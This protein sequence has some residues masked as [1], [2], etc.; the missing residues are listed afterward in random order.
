MQLA[1]VTR[2]CVIDV[3]K[4]LTSVT[5]NTQHLLLVL[6]GSVEIMFGTLSPCATRVAF[7]T[8]RGT[9][10]SIVVF[11]WLP[12]PLLLDVS[13]AGSPFSLPL[14]WSDWFPDLVSPSGCLP[15][16]RERMFTS[17]SPDSFATPSAGLHPSQQWLH[18]VVCAPRSR[19]PARGQGL[20]LATTRGVSRC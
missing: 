9:F 15:L 7:S 8:E 6:S 11:L 14:P 20:P 12:L 17:L 1:V 3:A 2:L 4:L 18:S 16:L 13:V 10:G 5:S 19:P